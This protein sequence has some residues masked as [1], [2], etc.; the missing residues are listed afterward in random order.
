MTEFP[1]IIN[2]RRGKTAEISS[3]EASGPNKGIVYVRFMPE[4]TSKD[5]DTH[6]GD[7][8]S[9]YQNVDVYRLFETAS[10]LVYKQGWP[11]ELRLYVLAI[12]YALVLF[13]LGWLYYWP[14]LV[15]GLVLLLIPLKRKRRIRIARAAV[16]QM[17]TSILEAAAHKVI[18]QSS[19][20]GRL[21]ELQPG[22]WFTYSTLTFWHPKFWE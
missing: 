9:Y 8:L 18:Q 16:L 20:Y 21:T 7:P 11:R 13:T 1:I 22:V 5:T 6:E 17:H 14:C 3:I 15:A 10:K 19:V 4:L 2:L 12:P